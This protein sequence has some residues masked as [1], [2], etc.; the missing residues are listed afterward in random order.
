MNHPDEELEVV[1]VEVL[2]E[3]EWVEGALQAQGCR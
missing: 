2:L 1:L 3:E